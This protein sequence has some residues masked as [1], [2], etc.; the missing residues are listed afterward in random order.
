MNM[1]NGSKNKNKTV[2]NVA[3]GQGQGQKRESIG[4]NGIGCNM[5]NA[6]GNK[7]NVLGNSIR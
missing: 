4:Y 6:G 2:S 1:S 3:Q 5:G 7:E